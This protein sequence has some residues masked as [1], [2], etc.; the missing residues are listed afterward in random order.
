MLRRPASRIERILS[1]AQVPGPLVGYMP[2]EI[3]LYREFTVCETLQFFARLL[4][5]SKARLRERQEFLLQL[6]DIEPLANRMI[7]TRWL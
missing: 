2:Q 3:A 6:L 7:G 4:G 5:M 1:T